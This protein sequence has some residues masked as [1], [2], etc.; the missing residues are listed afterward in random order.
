MKKL[1]VICA[2]STAAILAGAALLIGISAPKQPPAAKPLSDTQQQLAVASDLSALSTDFA[3]DDLGALE[4]LDIEGVTFAIQDSHLTVS[5]KARTPVWYSDTSG[6]F[7][8]SYVTGDFMVE[9]ELTSNLRSDIKA[10]SNSTF[11]S[12]GLAVRDP[13]STAGKMRWVVYDF[14]FQDSYFGTEIKTTRD[15]NGLSIDTLLG[16]SSLSTWFLN[17]VQGL[18]NEAKMRICRV[19][20]ELRFF[21]RPTK[22]AT[23]QEEI[24]G[25]NTKREG[26][27]EL[28]PGLKENSPLRLQRMDLPKT[29]QVG[30]MSNNIGLEANAESRYN[31]LRFTRINAFDRC[32]K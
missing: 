26:A 31:Y 18:G 2:C 7:L 3:S 27:S 8:Y 29:L 19:G 24:N 22:V 1:F 6:V 9:T 25:A 30:V 23:W 20:S 32:I 17:P 12:A 5:N 11:T 10:R 14:G 16:N 13:A 21:I 15:S 28:V 4:W